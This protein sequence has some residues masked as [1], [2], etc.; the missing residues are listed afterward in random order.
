[1]R[2][3][4]Y[5]V[6]HKGFISRHRAQ[7]EIKSGHVCVNGD[8][9]SKPSFRV[10]KDDLVEVFAQ[11]PYVS[12]GGVK[13]EAALRQFSLDFKDKTILDVGSSTGGF[14]DCALANG[15]K[16][17]YAVDVG[18]RQ[19]DPSLRQDSRVLLRENTNFLD[20]KTSDFSDIDVVIV[21]VSFTSGLPMVFHAAKLFEDA[22]ILALLKP[23]FEGGRSLKSGVVKGLK[24]LRRI[25]RGYLEDLGKA[26]LAPCAMIES[27]RQDKRGNREFFVLIDPK[28]PGQSVE[29]L[30][31]TINEKRC[32]NAQTP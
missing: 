3:D 21:D 19:M 20:I 24:P 6:A 8:V 32:P 15:A 30:L 1:M 9:V 22:T 7:Q 14:T 18:D 10:R 2:L 16:K 13:L 26:G 31:E 12:Y 5:L 11:N 4:Q 27:P 23:Q 17:V 28:R 29:A 25:V